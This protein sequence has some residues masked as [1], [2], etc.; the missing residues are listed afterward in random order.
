MTTP[1]EQSWNW[2]GT[3]EERCDLLTVYALAVARM[4]EIQQVCNRSISPEN[5]AA[6]AAAEAEVDSLTTLHLLPPLPS[7]TSS[8]R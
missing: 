6:L 2:T 8:H 5:A 1:N 7:P 4:R 3:T